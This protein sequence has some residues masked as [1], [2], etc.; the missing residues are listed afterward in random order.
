MNTATITK[1]VQETPSA[2]SVYLK[3][4]GNQ[5]Y[6]PGQFITLKLEINGQPVTRSYSFS[7]PSDTDEWRVTIKM[8]KGGLVSNHLHQEISV[9]DT[10]EYLG[11]DGMFTLN[12]EPS[13]E[14]HI[15][16]G[17]GSGITPLFSMLDHA[18]ND[19]QKPITLLYGSKNEKETIFLDHLRGWEAEY[20]NFEMRLFFSR[21][22]IKNILFSKK[23]P[24]HKGRVTSE[25]VKNWLQDFDWDPKHTA[26]YL[27]G[28]GE[29]NS[30]FK[31]VLLSLGVPSELINFEFFSSGPSEDVEEDGHADVSVTL[32]GETISVMVAK[33]QSVL[34]ALLDAGYDPPYSCSAGT[35]CTCMAH[36]PQGQVKMQRNDAL[37]KKE[38]KNGYVLTCQAKPISDTVSINY[39]LD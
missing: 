3:P 32:N 16:I 10:L 5:T 27:C 19:S 25:F 38:I 14:R 1:I 20:A 18:L 15:F 24:Y 31:Q 17:A 13:V 11:P 23:L 7:T 21:P 36:M 9:G 26:F 2:I 39:D 30:E 35:C 29:M 34:D 37:S 33:G 22:G 12:H 6:Q 8:V 4:D 28:P